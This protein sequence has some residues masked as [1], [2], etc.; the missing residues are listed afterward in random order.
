MLP[1]IIQALLD[2]RF[3]P[4]VLRQFLKSGQSDMEKLRRKLGRSRRLLQ[5]DLLSRT[6][7]LAAYQYFELYRRSLH[8]YDLALELLH[9]YLKT[10]DENLLAQALLQYETGEGYQKKRLQSRVK[11]SPRLSE[12]VTRAA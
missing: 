2:R 3:G 9:D 10:P 7:R 1:V 6:D 11:F 5:A 12:K 8:S 4:L